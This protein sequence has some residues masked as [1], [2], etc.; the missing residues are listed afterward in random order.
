MGVLTSWATPAARTPSEAR[1]S[2]SARARSARMR[3][4]MSSTTTTRR[5]GAPRK[6]ET[7]S[8]RSRSSPSAPVEP[9]LNRHSPPS[10][11]AARPGETPGS[12]S[13]SGR[14]ASSLSGR[15]GELGEGRVRGVD[16]V[17][18]VEDD[19]AGRGRADDALLVLLERAD[20]VQPL[21]QRPVEPGVLVREARLGEDGR[22]QRLVLGGERDRARPCARRRARPRARRRSASRRRRG[23]RGRGA[24]AAPGAEPRR[25]RRRAAAAARPGRAPRRAPPRPGPGPAPRRG[26][27]SRAR[28]GALPRPGGRS[29]GRPLRAGAGVAKSRAM[30]SR[31]RRARY[32]SWYWIR[33]STSVIRFLTGT[34]SEASTMP[35]A[36][37]ITFLPAA[38]I[39]SSVRSRSELSSTNVRPPSRTAPVVPIAS[40]TKISTSQ[41]RHFRIA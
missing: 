22:E 30:S 36:N 14:P 34:R 33:S 23:S 39:P 10:R 41:R 40:R 17:L 19:D 38:A 9:A 13:A 32:V 31:A 21:G 15:P 11:R 20:L 4:V 12:A 25:T 26:T 35:E 1:R 18:G 7:E 27:A 8:C 5:S 2:R 3:S 24:A 28:R 6:A 37:A 16:A 29:P